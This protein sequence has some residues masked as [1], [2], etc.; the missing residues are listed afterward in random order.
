MSILPMLP[1][2]GTYPCTIDCELNRAKL[3]LPPPHRTL[4]APDEACASSQARDQ[5]QA[6]AATYVTAAALPDL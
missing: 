6:A 5:I 3:D 2:T 1:Y 4:A